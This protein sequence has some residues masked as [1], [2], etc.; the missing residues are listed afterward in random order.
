[1][2]I[3]AISSASLQT[4]HYPKGTVALAAVSPLFT[5]FLLRYVCILYLYFELAHLTRPRSLAFRH[6]RFAILPTHFI[7]SFS[8][9]CRCAA[10]RREEMEPGCGMAGI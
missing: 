8:L 5:Y 1:M 10:F 2:G 9:S 7:L 6:L 4:S 3:W